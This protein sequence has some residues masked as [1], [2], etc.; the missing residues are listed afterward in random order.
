MTQ[1]SDSSGQKITELKNRV[2]ALEA[3]LEEAKELSQKRKSAIDSTRVYLF[4]VLPGLQET[5]T[6]TD[7]LAG[8]RSVQ[9]Q[10]SFVEIALLYLDLERDFEVVSDEG[11]DDCLELISSDECAGIIADLLGEDP[12]N[13][14]A[15]DESGLQEG[16]CCVLDGAL[17][18][19]NETTEEKLRAL[20]QEL[21]TSNKNL[22]KR[23]LG[24]RKAIEEACKLPSGNDLD[25][26]LGRMKG[27]LE[28]VL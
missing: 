17:A 1:Q 24:M 26:R 6:R 27:I 19:K 25:A 16:E 7:D 21:F 23:L 20:T 4:S 10:I 28:A 18:F 3:E 14:E 22:A 2:L 15:A 11:A 9:G 5:V 8:H 13:K 12:D